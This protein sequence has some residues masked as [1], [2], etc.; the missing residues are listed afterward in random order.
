MQGMPKPREK[1]VR[2][3]HNMTKFEKKC[4]AVRMEKKAKGSRSDVVHTCLDSILQNHKST[5]PHA[6]G[7]NNRYVRTFHTRS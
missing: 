5:E 1:S 3:T 4:S 2:Q 7:L 6:F